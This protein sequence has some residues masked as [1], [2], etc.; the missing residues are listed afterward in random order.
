TVFAG[1]VGYP[2]MG[3]VSHVMKVRLLCGI[4]DLME[5]SKLTQ[6]SE[7]KLESGI[8]I[9]KASYRK[10]VESNYGLDTS[11]SSLYDITLNVGNLSLEET[12]GSILHTAKHE[13]FQPMTYSLECVK[14]QIVSSR[15]RVH[16]SAYDPRSEVRS[17][18]GHVYVY[19]RG[20][21]LKRK[22]QARKL[23]EELI[24]LD[25]VQQVEVYNKK[26]M[27]ECVACGH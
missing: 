11:E 23:K 13:R 10:W 6:L 27:F 8:E 7:D 9:R 20:S 12:I 3:N 15:V 22:E 16:V 21:M 2:L 24:R 5:L 26:E 17:R 25:G 18:K 4:K 19:T 14:D 1:F